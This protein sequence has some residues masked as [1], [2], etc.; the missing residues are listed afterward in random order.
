MFS[1]I[2]IGNTFEALKDEFLLY[3]EVMLPLNESIE[4]LADQMT[5]CVETRDCINS[6]QET[7]KNDDRVIFDIKDLVYMIP[8]HLV[9]YRM[10][11]DSIATQASKIMKKDVEI[12]AHNRSI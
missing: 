6:L 11:M 12:E 1:H 5:Q 9:R 7:A 3:C 10:V 2:D 8:Q 4:F